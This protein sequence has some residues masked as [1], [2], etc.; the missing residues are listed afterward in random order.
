MMH[1][2]I[3][4]LISRMALVALALAAALSGTADGVRAEPPARRIGATGQ[5]LPRFV[6]LKSDEVNLRRGP[7]WDYP[8]TWVFRRAGLPVEILAEF[9]TWRQV[10]DSEGSTGWVF[11]SLLSGRRTSLVSPTGQPQDPV[12]LYEAPSDSAPVK[13]NLEKGLIVSIKNCNGR[14]CNVVVNDVA[15]WI[16]QNALWGVYPDEVIN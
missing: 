1:T 15:G 9:E 16:D 6:S 13:A 8:V 4:T 12:P 5:P 14:W 10:R 7:G 11:A 2:M 3:H